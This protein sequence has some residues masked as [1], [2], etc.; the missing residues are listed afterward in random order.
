VGLSFVCCICSPRS[1]ECVEYVR[2]VTQLFCMPS[3][4]YAVPDL[5]PFIYLQAR[6]NCQMGGF[7]RLLHT[8]QPDDLMK[9]GRCQPGKQ[10]GKTG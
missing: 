5:L 3:N 7:T 9:V 8:G 4:W 2:V 6:G 10:M 1:S